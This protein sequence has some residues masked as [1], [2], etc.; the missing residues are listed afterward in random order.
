MIYL[1]MA[2]GILTRMLDQGAA[3][4]LLW[5]LHL[6]VAGEQHM[7]LMSH[8]QTMDIVFREVGVAAH[9]M[10]PTTRHQ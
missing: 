6:T 5:R 3:P 9:A 10:L 8:K 2:N 4:R 1:T 7:K